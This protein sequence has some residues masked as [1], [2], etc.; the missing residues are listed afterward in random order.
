[1]RGISADLNLF[2]GNA[3]AGTGHRRNSS[4]WPGFAAGRVTIGGE[5]WPVNRWPTEPGTVT[6]TPSATQ[7]SIFRTPIAVLWPAGQGKEM[8]NHDVTSL[9][10]VH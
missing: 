3:L 1:M 2:P 4:D 7:I 9:L 6:G 5:F 10:W 8:G